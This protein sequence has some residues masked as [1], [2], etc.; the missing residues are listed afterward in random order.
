MKSFDINSYLK[1]KKELVDKTLDSI[2]PEKDCFPPQ[3]H[4]AMRHC[5][6]SGGKRL[7]PILALAAAEAVGEDCHKLL[8][9]ACSLELIHT[10]TLIHDDLPSMD[11]DN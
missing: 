10:Y 8:K 2:L 7:R 5:L 11:N 1:E 4:N 6:F 9:E 3:L